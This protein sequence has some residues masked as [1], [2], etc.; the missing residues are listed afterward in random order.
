MVLVGGGRCSREP[1][2]TRLGG[3]VKGELRSQH[4]SGVKGVSRSQRGGVPVRLHECDRR[5]D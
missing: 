2:T 4:G 1:G 5:W 3:G